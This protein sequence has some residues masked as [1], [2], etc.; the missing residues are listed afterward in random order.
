M[1]VGGQSQVPAALPPGK[2]PYPLHRRLGGLDGC[3]KSCPPPG[4]RSPD[5]P[6]RN[7]SL[8]RLCYPGPLGSNTHG[9]ECSIGSWQPLSCSLNSLPFMENKIQTYNFNARTWASNTPTS[10]I[11][12]T[13]IAYV[14]GT[15][16]PQSAVEA[17][18]YTTDKLWV[19]FR[20]GQR[21]FC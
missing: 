15:G 4:I 1:G 10:R 11:L 7:E 14:T 21:I 3:G 13:P 16:T 8:Y 17:T 9:K 5:L 12:Q 6:V 20:Q 19:N 18:A 2:T